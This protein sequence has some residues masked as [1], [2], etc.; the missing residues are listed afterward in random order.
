[1]KHNYY[2]DI[3]IASLLTHNPRSEGWMKVVYN[4]PLK[5]ILVLPVTPSD[6]NVDSC[7]DLKQ[8]KSEFF[9]NSDAS[10]LPIYHKLK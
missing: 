1:M 7:W 3:F 9:I 4:L 6:N 8:F 5:K 10:G 2:F